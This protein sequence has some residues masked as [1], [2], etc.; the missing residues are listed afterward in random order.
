MTHPQPNPADYSLAPA[1]VPEF[2]AAAAPLTEVQVNSTLQE[3]IR[4]LRE[5][6]LSDECIHGLF[7]GFNIDAKPEPAGYRWTLPLNSQLIRLIWGKIHPAPM[8]MD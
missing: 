8:Q 5:R 2:R 1:S 7:S 6:G 4:I 3:E